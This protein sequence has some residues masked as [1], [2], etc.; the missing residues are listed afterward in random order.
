[1][2][3]LLTYAIFFTPV[4]FPASFAGEWRGILLLNPVAPLLEAMSDT[5]ISHRPPDPWWT[6]YSAAVSIALF[7][8]GY[9]LFKRLEAQFAERL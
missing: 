6:T 4:L 9:W 5:V 2:E 1:V 7:V 8:A 3:V